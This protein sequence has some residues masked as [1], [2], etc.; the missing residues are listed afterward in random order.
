M[1]LSNKAQGWLLFLVVVMIGAGES[2]VEL[3]VGVL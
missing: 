2:L 3:L 1:E